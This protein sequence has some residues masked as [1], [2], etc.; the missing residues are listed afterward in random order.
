MENQHYSDEELIGRL[1]GL[2]ANDGHLDVC[3][4]CR[5]RLGAM[6]QR[7]SLVT[8]QEPHISKGFLAEQRHA[9]WA[10]IE[11]PAA[12][13]MFW[14]AASAFAGMAILVIGFL[15][16]QPMNTPTSQPAAATAT[17]SDAQLYADISTVVETPEPLAVTPIRGLFEE[18]EAGKVAQ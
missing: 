18:K 12:P 17:V 4:E 16:Y 11:K 14:K 10:R 7:Q 2:E 8:S 9:V 1:Y 5:S 3:P 6:K 13:Q 15:A